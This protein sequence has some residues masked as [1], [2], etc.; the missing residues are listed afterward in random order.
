M[1]A[2]YYLVSANLVSRN[3]FLTSFMLNPKCAI[4]L[5]T[6]LMIGHDQ[7]HTNKNIQA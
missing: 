7:R 2:D 4:R 3:E 6:G 1:A 5:F